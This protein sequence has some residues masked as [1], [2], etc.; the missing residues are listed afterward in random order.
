MWN[1]KPRQQSCYSYS[2]KCTVEVWNHRAIFSLRRMCLVENE[3]R[4]VLRVALKA[5]YLSFSHLHK[6]KRDENVGLMNAAGFTRREDTFTPSRPMCVYWLYYSGQLCWKDGFWR[7]TLVWGRRHR[8]AGKTY[9]LLVRF[10]W[11]PVLSRRPGLLAS[12]VCVTLDSHWFITSS[13]QQSRQ[14]VKGSINTKK[15]LEVLSLLRPVVQWHI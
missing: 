10:S 13:V 12:I 5:E 15:T 2:V 9:R 7:Y 3:N 8:W 6:A 11:V 1:K 4:L 14:S